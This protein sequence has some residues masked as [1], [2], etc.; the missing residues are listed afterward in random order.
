MSDRV[1][2]VVLEV[3][4]VRELDEGHADPPMLGRST[5]QNLLTLGIRDVA[6]RIGVGA[7]CRRVVDV[8]GQRRS[9]HE[10]PAAVF[11]RF[12]D[13]VVGNQRGCRRAQQ[14]LAGIGHRL[15]VDGLCGAA[16]RD[17]EIRVTRVHRVDGEPPGVHA[18]RD[19]QLHATGRHT[20]QRPSDDGAHLC[21]R[22]A[23]PGG[24]SLT[25]EQH[26]QRVTAELDDVPELLVDG[27]DHRTEVV[28]EDV[29]QLLGSFTTQRGKAF[30]KRG[31]AG[32]VR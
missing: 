23:C 12:T 24:V 32:D 20:N 7:M 11:E 25:A 28:V 2:A 18:L 8:A 14:D 5:H 29:G 3:I 27:I 9:G 4:G 6:R 10:Q 16:T 13:H 30:R 22:T 19:G 17:D 31:E 26:Q 1:G 15:A 21:R